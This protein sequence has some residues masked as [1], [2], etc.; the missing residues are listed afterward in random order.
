MRNKPKF[1]IY[2]EDE[3]CGSKTSNH[4]HIRFNIKVQMNIYTQN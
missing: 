1:Q 3:Q 2:I 4:F